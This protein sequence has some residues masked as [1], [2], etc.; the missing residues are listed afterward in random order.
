MIPREIQQPSGMQRQAMV[1]VERERQGRDPSWSRGGGMASSS[2]RRVAA[3]SS[4]G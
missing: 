3:G 1:P 2:G 4:F